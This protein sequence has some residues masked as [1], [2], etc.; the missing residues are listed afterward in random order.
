LINLACE[1]NCCV[2]RL[3]TV[4]AG[5]GVP[6]LILMKD[7]SIYLTCEKS[8]HGDA[9]TFG[10][11]EIFGFNTGATS[12]KPVAE[13]KSLLILQHRGVANGFVIAFH[14]LF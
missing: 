13:L 12:I 10:P 14:F 6:G 11:G 9:L 4:K 5:R 3:F 8:A 2:L 7:Y 1:L